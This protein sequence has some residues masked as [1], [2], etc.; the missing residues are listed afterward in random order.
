MH[1]QN[2]Y[3][4]WVG[5]SGVLKVEGMMQFEGI[6]ITREPCVGSDGPHMVCVDWGDAVGSRGGRR[7][8]V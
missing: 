7:I 3:F 5:L 4:T 6:Y 1:V 8:L 2:S